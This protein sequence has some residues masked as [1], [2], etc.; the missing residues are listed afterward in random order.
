MHPPLKRIDRDPPQVLGAI[1]EIR[2]G[3]LFKDH[4]EICRSHA[5]GGQM[6]MRV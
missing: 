5:L 4:K 2:V 6:A 1:N 3:K